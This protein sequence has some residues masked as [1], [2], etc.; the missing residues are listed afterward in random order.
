MRWEREGGIGSNSDRQVEP[1]D[2]LL[3]AR[4]RAGYREGFIERVGGRVFLR[5]SSLA[6]ASTRKLSITRL[7]T[8][9]HLS[10]P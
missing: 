7:A 2:L 6:F 9:G 8:V 5:T 1:P 4:C 10:R 3:V